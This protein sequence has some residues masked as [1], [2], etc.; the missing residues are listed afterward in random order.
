MNIK[1]DKYDNEGRGI[2]Y[3]NNKIVFVP[4]TVIGETVKASIIQEKEKYILA[5]LDQVITPS[6]IRLQSKCPYYDKCG[7]CSFMHISLDEELRIKHNNLKELFK[8]HNL[9]IND[10]KIIQSKEKYNYRNK[11]T[12]KI[13]DNNFG[14]YNESSHDFI[15]IKYCYLAKD[16]INNIIKQQ[17]LFNIKEG[18]ITIRSNYN[19]EILIKID[20]KEK[21]TINIEKL[22]QSNKI[23][24]I[25]INNKTIYGENYYIEK[26]NN[27]LFK[28]NINS[29]FQVNN[30]ILEQISN[31]LNKK[32]YNT[33]VDL[34]CGV[35]VLGTFINKQKCYG[36]EIIPDA[37][38]NAITNSK[39]NKQNNLYMLGDSS[40]I[41]K[42]KDKIDCIMIDPPRSGLNK[43]T[44]KNIIKIKPQEL[45]YMSCNPIT[46]VRDL[47]ILN[48]LYNI[49]ETYMLEMFP[50]TKHVE[51]IVKLV[52]KKLDA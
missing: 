27:Y 46:L 33:I 40:N 38:T 42:I 39:M 43:E 15:K 9:N 12:L 29:F 17:N 32:T 19:N 5:K 18:E 26:I 6:S 10:I 30:N 36:I 21:P 34:Y 50:R 23:V 49:E 31:I 44:L 48:N 16:S 13:K 35:G 47:Q 51:T 1:I 45:I 20:T 24:G 2:G 37:I 41:T 11:I 14:Y 7:A 28:V 3:Y 25:I 4:N 22:I 52:R 8:R